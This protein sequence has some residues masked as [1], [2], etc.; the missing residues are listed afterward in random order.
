MSRPVPAIAFSVSFLLPALI[1]IGALEG[2]WWLA[3]PALYGWIATSLLDG[4][5]G[6]E[7]EG[8]A[9]PEFTARALAWRRAVVAAW[10]P[11]QIALIAFCLAVGV[12]GWLS[13]LE[14]VALM[15]GLG[16]ATGGVGITY[17]HELVHSR[18]RW[19]RRLGRLL[20]A[21]VGYGHFEIEHV[22]GHHVHV[23]TP[24]DPVTARY[25]EGFWRFLPR[26]VIG[27]AVSGWE[28]AARRMRRLDRPV[29]SPANPW[30]GYLAL[31][32]GFAAGA[33]A[34]GGWLGLGLWAL[35]AVFAI[36]QLEAVNYIEHYGLV[37]L[38]RDD[39]RYEPQRAHHSWN[40]G[41][42]MT[43]WL[44]INL[45]LH[46]DHHARPDR[47]YPE[48]RSLPETEAPQLPFGYPL[49]VLIA[50][51]PPLW[52]RLMNPRVKA[53]RKRHYPEVEDWAFARR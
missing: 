28:I 5:L 16:I 2:G 32:A 36:L 23:G 27:T 9:S 30:A 20:L 14:T 35:Q 53:W 31:A 21:S 1:V 51:L 17:A 43:N 22:A 45:Q 12:S 50:M 19:E 8:G 18:A 46:S 40:A 42:R 10:V 37:R 33:C 13:A 29:L 24:E 6:R 26:A 48:L 41:Q 25:S 34:I 11:V 4:L 38:R 49:M 7:P 44:L 15:A 39:G 47:R 3:L 52:F